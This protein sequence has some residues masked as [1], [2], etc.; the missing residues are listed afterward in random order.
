MDIR[1]VKKGWG[2]ELIF[3]NTPLYCGKLLH[4]VQNEMSSMHFHAEKTETFFVL[5][6][7]FII[8]TI[9]TKDAS[10]KETYLKQGDK[11]D[12]AKFQPHKIIAVSGGDIVEVSTHDD[13]DDSYRVEAGSSQRC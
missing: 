8:V 2:Y 7:E 4:F 3:A 9:N 12:I 11:M 1:R 6:G 13:E 5:S 10:K